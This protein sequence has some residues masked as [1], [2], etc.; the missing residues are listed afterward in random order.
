[1]IR[2]RWPQLILCALVAVLLGCAG[3]WM[4]FTNFTQNDDE[5][6]DLLS[7]RQFCAGYPL[8]TD[9]FSQYGPLFYA[10]YRL[11]HAATG[12]VFTSESARW[13]TLA[14]WLV[15]AGACGCLA[16]RLTQRWLPTVAA[17]ILSFAA[18]QEIIREPFHP[19]GILATLAAVGAAICLGALLRGATRTFAIAGA[20]VGTAMALMKINVG[21]FFL[22]SVGSWVALH[23]GGRKWG[24]VALVLTALGIVVLPLVLMK[25]HLHKAWVW[26][27]VL[28]FAAS[29]LAM[30]VTLQRIGRPAE[31]T[32][33]NGME[34]IVAVALVSASMVVLYVPMGTSVAH[35]WDGVVISPLRH[36]A[37]NTYPI[38]W[39]HGAVALAIL[40]L[41]TA[42]VQLAPAARRATVIAWLRLLGGFL[43]LVQLTGLVFEEP[44]HAVFEFAPA[45]AWLMATP[46]TTAGEVD[47]A[48]RGRSWLG[49]CA[50]W[51][52]LQ[53]Y[54]VGGSQ[55][56]WGAFLFVPLLVVGSYDAIGLLLKETRW[57][58]LAMP[59]G[60]GLLLA[61]AAIAQLQLGSDALLAY[62]DREPLGLPGARSLRLSG[63]RTSEFRVIAR[64]VSAHGGLLYGAPGLLS[65]NI[66][67]QKPTPTNANTT[68]WGK[69][70]NDE[71]KAEIS[72]RLQRDRTCLIVGRIVEGRYYNFDNFLSNFRLALYVGDYTL[73][74]H[75]EAT[76]LPLGTARLEKTADGRVFFVIV[77]DPTKCSVA[78]LQIRDVERHVVAWK[79]AIPKE[80]GWRI[81]PV[82]L[83]AH[84]IGETRSETRPFL[85][86]DYSLIQ[87]EISPTMKGID[88]N[89]AEIA[90]VDTNG[91]VV[92]SYRFDK[93][94]RTTPFAPR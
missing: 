88:L 80:N 42:L 50:I 36:P 49:W 74:T 70:L 86:P 91:A 71:Q 62:L 55:M 17:A 38:R 20:V 57:P 29:G 45:L 14:Y 21:V 25:A 35:F 79:T 76:I 40:S 56:A 61:L 59:L 19:G 66:W 34:M 33:R 2:G 9:V 89:Q 1:M 4:L 48:A 41:V 31:F 73:W 7:V 44:F 87:V 37:L 63:A 23:S 51:G 68:T 69:L 24:R 28:V 52:I 78:E 84:V 11:W 10:W 54:P 47:P 60:G 39:R 16:W 12:L 32:V 58:R 83:H 13:L 18:L 90:L 75:K 77:A 72:T 92:D 65:F 15:A 26:D 94:P 81:T 93:A 30:L 64:N 46:L 5:G 53:A 67:T 22:I 27:F 43:V 3:Y 8:Y 85:L 82:D 6:Y